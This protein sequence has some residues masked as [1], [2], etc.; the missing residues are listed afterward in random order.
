MGLYCKQDN[1]FKGPFLPE[2]SAYS[3]ACKSRSYPPFSYTPSL[4]DKSHYAT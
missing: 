3:R 1:E 2:I 4:R